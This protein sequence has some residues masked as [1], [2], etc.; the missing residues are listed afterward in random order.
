MVKITSANNGLHQL[1]GLRLRFCLRGKYS[2]IFNFIFQINSVDLFWPVPAAATEC[3]RANVSGKRTTRNSKTMKI[4][5]ILIAFLF[6]TCIGPEYTGPP[7][8]SVEAKT[9]KVLINSYTPN[10]RRVMINDNYY[11]IEDAWTSFNLPERFSK[12]VNKKTYDFYVVLKDEKTGN[13]STDYSF[14][15]PKD[16]VKYNGKQYGYSIGVGDISGMLAV[17]FITEKKQIADDTLSF[18]LINSKSQQTLLFY[19]ENNASH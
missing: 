9:N 8:S 15:L 19:K 18:T 17:D 2:D 7:K 3:K 1:L 13:L 4:K 11:L 10:H 5:H 6:V 14:N 12:K 16:Y